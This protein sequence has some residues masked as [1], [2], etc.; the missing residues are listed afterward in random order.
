MAVALPLFNTEGK[1][2]G[3][4]DAPEAIFGKAMNQ[5]L[6]QAT[7]VWYRACQRAGTHSSKTRSE[8]SGGGVK[9]WKQKGTGRARAGSNRSPLWRKGGVVFGPKPRDYSFTLPKKMRKQALAMVLS[10]KARE[11]KLQVIEAFK[12][13]EPKTKLA[14]AL[15]SGLGVSG[16]SLLILEKEN[17]E[18]NRA[19]RNLADVKIITVPNLN[20]F[21]LLEAEWVVVE[22][23]AV[24]KMQ[25]VL[26]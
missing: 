26:A 18:F 1:S 7:L 5:P 6:V 15:V 23:A 25:E 2:A 13:K 14:K 8:V 10:D 16:K 12:V 22:K 20:I 21:D 9:P 4:L 3:Q 17:V 24:N 19:A 11:G